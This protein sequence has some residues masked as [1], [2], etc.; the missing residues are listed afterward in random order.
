M[1]DHDHEPDYEPQPRRAPAGLY[2]TLAVSVLAVVVL[3]L[4]LRP[5]SDDPA[6]AAGPGWI[7]RHTVL[8]TVLFMV[9]ADVILLVSFTRDIR[10]RAPEQAALWCLVLLIGGLLGAVLWLAARPPLPDR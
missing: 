7:E 2:A 6:P 10:R 3:V 1:I 4:A 5:D 9:V 8:L